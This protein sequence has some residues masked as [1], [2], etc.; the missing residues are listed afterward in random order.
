[1]T[2]F[3]LSGPPEPIVDDGTIELC[4]L[5]TVQPGDETVVKSDKLGTWTCDRCGTKNYEGVEEGSLPEPEGCSGC[6]RNG[7]YNHAGEVSE[8][9]VQT[10][11]RASQMWHPPTGYDDDLTGFADIWTDTRQFIYDHW[12]AGDGEE[13]DAIYAGLTA[14]ALTTWFRPNLTFVPH[15]MLMGQTTGG[16]T[17]LLNTLARVSYRAVV[18][19]S[20]TPATLYRMIDA[21][22][23]SFFVSEYHG[24]SSDSRRE[25]DNV[26]RA[27]QKRGEI[28]T[29]AEQTNSGYEPQIYDPFSH[30]AIATQYEPDDDIVNRC[31]RIP[32]SPANRD[33]PPTHDEEQAADIR[34]RL[35]FARYRLLDSSDWSKAENATYKYLAE[36]GI[37]GRTREKLLSIITVAK[38][39][40]RMDDIEP[41]VDIVVD[42]DRQAAADSEDAQFTQVVRDLAFEEIGNTTVLTDKDPYAAVEIPYSEIVEQYEAMTGV[43][44]SASWVG[45][46]R[47]RLGIEKQRKRD[48]TV[49]QD[50]NLGSKLRRLCEEH[51]L[52]WEPTDS[53]DPVEELPEN[54]QGQLN[55][56][57]CGEQRAT[58]RV[59]TSD[60]YVE[61]GTHVCPDCADALRESYQ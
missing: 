17:R 27:G 26:V 33:M 38:L 56:S 44:K 15:L 48:E 1:M 58:H 12:D 37:T 25:L 6:D 42:Q 57:E 32:S 49:I 43:E 41:F 53:H 31:I 16:K 46:V 7:P 11:L 54:D 28:V 40:G 51:N 20:A 22:D 4:Y 2:D 21:Y 45:H 14:Y 39:W 8:S 19:A 35:L 50:E 30:I 5:D 24:L 9:D 52:P 18:S 55:C 23:V 47:S 60:T 13:S 59:G 10:G 3:E 34:N 61:K 29:R 36:R